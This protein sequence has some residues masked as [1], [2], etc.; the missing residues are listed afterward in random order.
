MEADLDKEQIT[1]LDV[2]LHC[3]RVDFDWLM[4]IGDAIV[5]LDQNL[6]Q[7]AQ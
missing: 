1:L 7:L 5:Y 3:K 4:K 2:G 6:K